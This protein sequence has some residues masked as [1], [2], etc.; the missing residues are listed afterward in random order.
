MK[1]TIPL[2]ELFERELKKQWVSKDRKL[3][4]KGKLLPD[5]EYKTG[6]KR[7]KKVDCPSCRQKF[8]YQYGYFDKKQ[9]KHRNITS[10]DLPKLRKKIKEKNLPWGVENKEYAEKTAKNIGISLKELE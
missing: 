3:G 5:D 2:K 4:V 7:T 6:F 9:Q 10:I 8:T 1:E